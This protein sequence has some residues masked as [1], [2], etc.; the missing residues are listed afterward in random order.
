MKNVC[1]QCILI[2]AFISCLVSV[3]FAET[4]TLKWKEPVDGAS[5]NG[6]N[7]YYGLSNDISAMTKISGITATS[8]TVSG[9]VLHNH[10]YFYVKA[11]NANGEGPAS[12]VLVSNVSLRVVE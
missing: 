2:A 8:Y 9:L 1:K 5:V 7:L 6:Y 3:S 10:Y 11:Y 12:D 4:V